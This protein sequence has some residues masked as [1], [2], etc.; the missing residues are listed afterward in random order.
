MT[1]AQSKI[2]AKAR[3]RHEELCGQIR[4]HDRLYYVEGT[5]EISD[6]DY[7]T[8][9]SEL[10]DLEEKHPA[11]V[12]PESPTQRIGGEPIEGFETVEHAV[13]ML[14]IDNTYNDDELRKFDERVRKGLDGEQAAYVVELKIDGVSI[15]LRYVNGRIERGA[16]RGDGRRGDDVTQ[17]IRA[18]ASVPLKLDD[19]PPDAFD[20]RGEVYMTDAELARLNKLREDEGLPLLANPRNTTAGTLKLLDTKESAKRKLSFFAYDIALEEGS[21]ASSHAETLETL[22]KYGLPVNPH[23]TRCEDIDAVLR[24]CDTWR[25]KRFDL[26]YLIDGLVIKVDD[27]EQ[28]RALGYTS[29]APRWVIAYKYPAEVAQTKLKKITVQIGKS[30]ALTPVAEVEPVQLAGT[31]VRRASLYNFDDLANKDLREGDMVEIQKAGEIIPQ[32]L[33][34]VPEKRPKNAKKFPV[35]TKCPD[36]GSPVVKDPEGVFIRCINLSCPDQLKGR[37]RH[38]ASRAAMDIDGMGEAIVEQ[39]VDRE[40]VHNPA[41]L[42]DLTAGEFETLERMGP[43]SSENLAKAIGRSKEQP[44]SRLLH[45]LG[46]R[47]VGLHTAEM[48]SQKFRNAE[49]LLKATKEDLV[50]VEDV[51]EVVAQSVV[52]FLSN[53]E[54]QELLQRFKD[55]GLKLEE[56]IA[57]PAAESGQSEA[58]SGKTFVVTGTLANYT[59]DAIEGL[60]KSHGGRVTSSVSKNTDYLV[61]GEKAGSKLTK[62]QSLD[63][64]ILSEEEFDAML[65]GSA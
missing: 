61:A 63:V 49:A 47:H 37:L 4:Y 33:R 6:Q 52:D 55:H 50:D 23:W 1:A 35:P 25:E 41:D 18:I 20:V 53:P 11:L 43:K 13:P 7:D 58:I 24:V 28:R 34:Y 32:V 8:L 3:K 51:G 30:G 44:L 19:D 38:F 54:N 59:R 57:G 14:S 36:C 16:T 46:I 48:I 45:G 62:A 5:N 31:T 15:S 9:Y 12:T 27:H 22:K 2:P 40:M 42:Y 60:I 56:S 65:D 29:K 39:L 64:R 21:P 26:G 17:N 10:V